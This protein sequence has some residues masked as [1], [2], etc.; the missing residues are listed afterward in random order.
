MNV[1][2][3]LTPRLTLTPLRMEHSAGMFKLWSDRAVCRYSGA[4]EDLDGRDVTLPATR[5]SDSDKIIRYF[6]HFEGLGVRFRW[7]ILRGRDQ[8][9]IGIIGFNDVGPSCE[10]AYHLLPECWG[11]GFMSEAMQ[12]A[13]QW[14]F[15]AFPGAAVTA[16]IEPGNSASIRLAERSG[17][18]QTLRERDGATEYVLK[19]SASEPDAEV[20]VFPAR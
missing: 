11:N 7:A 14:A 15:D 18:V 20:D 2:V 8:R 17:F 5:P 6:E 13:L 10:I 1:P 12:A 19:G 3:L 16:Y 9:F 4:A